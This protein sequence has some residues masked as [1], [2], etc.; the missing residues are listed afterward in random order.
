[1]SRN[2][3]VLYNCSTIYSKICENLQLQTHFQN[4]CCRSNQGSCVLL[5][6]IQEQKIQIYIVVFYGVLLSLNYFKCTTKMQPVLRHFCSDI[7]QST[8]FWKTLFFFY[9][10]EI[11]Y[12][13]S[14]HVTCFPTPTSTI[15]LKLFIKLY[16]GRLIFDLS[17]KKCKIKENFTI[18]QL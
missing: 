7:I 9:I 12:M 10:F 6:V 15:S 18:F 8:F 11:L 5:F 2:D 3:S 1:M 4:S 16:W 13:E 17:A 14:F